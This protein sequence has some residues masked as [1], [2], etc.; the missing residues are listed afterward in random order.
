MQIPRKDSERENLSNEHRTVRGVCARAIAGRERTLGKNHV[1]Q[2][3]LFFTTLPILVCWPRR[4]LVWLPISFLQYFFFMVLHTRG[5][6]IGN[7]D[8]RRACIK[9]FSHKK[10]IPLDVIYNRL[11]CGSAWGVSAEI[12]SE[13]TSLVAILE[14]LIIQLLFLFFMHFTH[15]F[16]TQV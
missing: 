15:L 1:F 7:Y 12:L 13:I 5:E 16:Q 8:G 6:T 14:T 10:E 11:S 4:R 9:R 3:V 2:S